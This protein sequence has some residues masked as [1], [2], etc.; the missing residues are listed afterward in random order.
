[1]DVMTATRLDSYEGSER[2]YI[3][4]LEQ[5]VIRLRTQIEGHGSHAGAVASPIAAEISRTLPPPSPAIASSQDDLQIVHYVPNTSA[6]H[7]GCKRKRTSNPVW[8]QNAKSLVQETPKAAHWEQKLK[9]KGLYDIMANGKALT[10]LLD[11]GVQPNMS[12]MPVGTMQTDK[13]DVVGCVRQYAYATATRTMAASIAV[14]LANFQRFLVLS[15]CA[16]L[17]EERVEAAEVLNIAKICIGDDVSDEYCVRLVRSAT[18]MNEL[19]DSLNLRG[20]G[21]RSSE[22]L[23]LC[24]STRSVSA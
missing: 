19:I 23:L 15:A 13:E 24:E 5:T 4:Y 18:Y 14:T 8:L 12:A 1:M 21:Y 17:L 6:N 9:E 11:I 20:W 3:R 16:V 2:S 7:S 22:L 10:Y